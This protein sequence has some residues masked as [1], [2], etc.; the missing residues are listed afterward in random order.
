[1]SSNGRNA[2]ELQSNQSRF[3][4]VTAALAFGELTRNVEESIRLGRR[5]E[6]VARATSVPAGVVS[7]DVVDDERSV[8]QHVDAAHRLLQP[9]HVVD[10]DAV[11]RPVHRH[12]VRVT[13]GLALEPHP[14]TFFGRRVPRRNHYVHVAYVP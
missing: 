7:V 12:V 5:T 9:R 4:L 14:A 13:A 11:Q 2:V 3:V 10:V 6:P 1:M 8:R